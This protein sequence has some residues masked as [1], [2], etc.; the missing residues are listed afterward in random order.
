MSATLGGLI[1]DYRLQKSIS[2]LE[3]AFALGWKEPS[4]LSRIEQGKI[5]KPSRE[6][7]DKLIRALKLSEEEKNQLLFTGGY[8]PT[9]EEIA[10]FR[11]KIRQKIDGWPYPASAMDFS[12]RV[13]CDNQVLYSMYHI[14]KKQADAIKKEKLHILKIVF[15]PEFILNHPKNDEGKKRRYA[16]LIRMLLHFQYAQRARTREKWYQNLIKHMMNNN[17]F[18]MLWSESQNHTSDSYDVSNYAPKF[19]IPA[20]DG[21]VLNLYMFLVPILKDP[22]FTVEFYVPADRETFEYF[23]K[24]KA[25]DVLR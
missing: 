17:L 25:S 12:W 21:G 19:G 10:V 8:L 7:I 11:D 20:K 9:D 2:Q 4:R 23:N 22:R 16:F 13:V 24:Q 6:L 18:K 3:I 15:N 5:E 14:S 1:K